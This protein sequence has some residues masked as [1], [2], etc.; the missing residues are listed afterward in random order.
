MVT[1]QEVEGDEKMNKKRLLM[2]LLALFILNMLNAN[3]SGASATPAS[4]YIAVAPSY[5]G[6]QMTDPNLKVSI[7]TDYGGS[8]VY[9]WHVQL[10][11]NATVLQC[12]E[13]VNGDLITEAKDPNAVFESEI[14][15]V[16]GEVSAGAYFYYQEPD[17]PPTTNG[18]GTLVNI[19]FTGVAYGNSSLALGKETKLQ[20]Y[21]SVTGLMYPIT[22]A[23]LHPNR[24]GHGAIMMTIQGDANM[25]KTV[26]VFD[27][28]AVKSRWGRTPAS[29]DW[30]PEC[31]CNFDDAINV[32]DIL[33]VKAH[34]GQSW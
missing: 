3:I 31:D 5:R 34:W 15:N 21:N 28:L 24:I 22:E 13:V 12:I 6:A 23:D 17:I 29:P 30:I 18:P 26:N 19:T 4:P 16:N 8:D 33:V 27:I 9:L 14:D 10:A 20:G 2:T 1:R 11:F 25:D 32:F 7:D